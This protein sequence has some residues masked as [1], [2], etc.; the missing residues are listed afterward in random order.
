MLLSPTIPSQDTPMSFTVYSELTEAEAASHWPLSSGFSS[1]QSELC[2]KR[3]QRGRVCRVPAQPHQDKGP[4]WL[5]GFPDMW[6]LCRKGQCLCS[7]CLSAGHR[8]G[9]R[10]EAWPWWQRLSHTVHH[11]NLSFIWSVQM[12]ATDGGGA[13]STSEYWGCSGEK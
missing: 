11:P 7:E 1:G 6:R 2:S 13:P 4:Q 12:W 5:S 10:Q 3:E 9:R 8:G